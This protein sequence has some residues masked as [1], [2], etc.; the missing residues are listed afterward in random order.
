MTESVAK[1]K[2]KGTPHASKPRKS[3]TKSPSTAGAM[4]KPGVR[5]TKPIV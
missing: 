2:A 5:E 1:P 3:A 4:A